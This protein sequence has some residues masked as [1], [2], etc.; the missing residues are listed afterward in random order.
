MNSCDLDDYTQ[1]CQGQR[2]EGLECLAER[3]GLLSDK[4]QGA[5]EELLSR[6]VMRIVF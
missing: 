6:G 2:I 3:I 5:L 4:P 1:F